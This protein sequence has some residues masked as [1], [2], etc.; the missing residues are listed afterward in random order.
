LHAMHSVVDWLAFG[1][2]H[3]GALVGFQV[4]ASA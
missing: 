1:V 3:G 4:R 2:W